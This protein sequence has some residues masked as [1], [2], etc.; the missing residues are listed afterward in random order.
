VAK[1][2]ARSNNVISW[3]SRNFYCT[4]YTVRATW[5]Y[6]TVPT[7]ELLSYFTVKE[8]SQNISHNRPPNNMNPKSF[9][10][11]ISTFFIYFSCVLH[12]STLNTHSS[13]FTNPMASESNAH[14]NLLNIKGG[15]K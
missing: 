15:C 2:Y 9:D 4:T 8:N 11:G 14:S 10:V 3:S 7:P 1:I 6:P 13:T 5:I 12:I